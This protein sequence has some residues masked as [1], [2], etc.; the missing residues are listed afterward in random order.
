MINKL[1]VSS[2]FPGTQDPP[3][4]EGAADVVAMATSDPS[5][6]WH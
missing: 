1:I 3:P 5:V 2:S 4:N 6:P